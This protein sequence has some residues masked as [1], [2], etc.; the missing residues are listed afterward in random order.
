IKQVRAVLARTH[1]FSP[2]DKRAIQPFSREEFRPVIDGITIGLQIFLIVIGGLTLGIG[3]VGV[4][5]IM[6]VSVTE[7]TREIGIRKAMGAT[8]RRILLQFMFEALALTAIGGL[9]GMALSWA[10]IQ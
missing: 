9:L 4:M 8:R 5:N 10:M 3:G 7:R 2:S 6:L 1:R